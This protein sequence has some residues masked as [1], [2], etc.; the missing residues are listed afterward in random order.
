MESWRLTTPAI[1]T[2]RGPATNGL[3][4]LAACLS[5]LVSGDV[6]EGEKKGKQMVS[7]HN[8][9]RVRTYIYFIYKFIFSFDIIYTC[10]FT[11]SLVSS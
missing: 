2:G 4:F 5:R 3:R 8:S 1:Q 7:K 10:V 9:A 6:K 11:S